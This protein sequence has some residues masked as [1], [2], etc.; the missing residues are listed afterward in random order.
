MTDPHTDVIGLRVEATPLV[1]ELRGR[2]RDGNSRPSQSRQET[3][4]ARAVRA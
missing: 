1:Y 4:N 3:V 2:R